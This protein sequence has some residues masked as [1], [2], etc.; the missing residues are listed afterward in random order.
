MKHGERILDHTST[1]LTY[2][3]CCRNLSSFLASQGA[4]ADFEW[5]FSEDVVWSRG[6]LCVR[7]GRQP[8]DDGLVR[9][10]LASPCASAFGVE[11]RALGITSGKSLCTVFLP[12]SARDAE[13]RLIHGL[14]FA[15]PVRLPHA[16][17]IR[18]DAE[19]TALFDR[20]PGT[21]TRVESVQS[22]EALRKLIEASGP[23]V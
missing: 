21:T 2:E 19:W 22:R 7:A 11:F 20:P 8:S 4:P 6:E 12:Q 9:I 14:K 17:I 3:Y 16:R 10:A 15:V 13:L 5:A 18:T 1:N 23:S